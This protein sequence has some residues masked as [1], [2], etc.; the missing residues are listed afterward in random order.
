MRRKPQ[1]KV[2][3]EFQKG[4]EVYG[5]RPF[6]TYSFYGQTCKMSSPRPERYHIWSK[7]MKIAAHWARVAVPC[8]TSVV[9]VMPSMMPLPMAQRMASTA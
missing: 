9:E 2:S 4:P 5:L 3:K 1:Q 8:G 6:P 7:R